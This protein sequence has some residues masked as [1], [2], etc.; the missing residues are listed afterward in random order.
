MRRAPHRI[1]R[2]KAAAAGLTR[3]QLARASRSVPKQ[4]QA[5]A[6]LLHRFKT[7]PRIADAGLRF[8]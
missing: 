1:A 6:A 8:R 7:T 4:K 5:S 3:R 2:P